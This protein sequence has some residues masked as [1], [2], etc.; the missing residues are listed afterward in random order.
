MPAVPPLKILKASAGSGK[1]FSLTAQYLTLLFADEHKYR[2]I[3]AITFTNKA[4]AEMKGRILGV[5]EALAMGDGNKGDAADG[6]REILLQAYPQWDAGA[7]Q[8]RAIAA[9]RKILHDYSR[10]AI[11]TIDGFTQKVIRGFTFELGIDAGYKLEMN[12]R[13]VKGD[14]VLRLN[15]TLDERPDL[16]QWIMDYAQAKIDRD[17]N[18][19]YRWAL[20]ELAAEIFKED[21][22]DFDKAVSAIPGQEL[23]VNL[24]RYCKE[25]IKQFEEA[26]EQLLKTA[27]GAFA[28]SGVDVTDLLGKSR[29]YLGKLDRFSAEDPA[30]AVKKLEKYIHNPA[31]W[32]KGGVNGNMAALYDVLNPLLEQIH[33]LYAEQSPDYYLAK[34]MDENLYYLRLLKEM[35]VL[36]AEWRHDNAAQLISDAQIL[37]SNIGTDQAGDP[38]FIWEKIGNRFRHFLFDEFQDTSKRQ[39]DNLRPLLINAMGNATGKRHEH[40]IVGDVKQSIYRWRNGDWRILLDRAEQ[41]IGKAF[42]TADTSPLIEHAALE[43]NYRSHEHIVAFNNLVF[44]HAPQ[45]LQQRLNDRVLRELGEAE[46]EHW[47]QPSGSHDM[48]IRAYADSRQQLPASARRGGTVHVEFIDVENNNHR[49]SAVKDEALAR[50]ADT[51]IGWLS[52]G[53][54]R[55]NQV[56]IL[57]RTNNE[58]REIIQYLLD[59]QRESGTAFDVV[60]GDALA[61]V[62]HPAIRLLVDTLRALA[63]KLPDTALYLANCIYLHNQLAG[64]A[65]AVAAHDWIQVGK[66]HP[67]QLGGM[68]PELLCNNWDMWAQLPLAELVE[69]LI[70][71]YGLQTNEES[72]PYLLAFRDLVAAFTANGERGIPAFLTYWEEEGIDRALPAAGETAAVEVL[73]IHKSKGLAF[74]V[75]MIPFCSWPIDGRINGNFWVNTEDTPYALLSK[76]PVKYKGDLGKSRLYQAYFEEMLLNYMDALNTL[77][78]A[79]TRT[80]KHLYIT[81]PGKKGDGEISALL[82]SDLLLEV[83]PGIAGELDV[84]FSDGIRLGTATE[85][86]TPRGQEPPQT[87]WSFSHY[88]ASTRMKEELARPEIQTELDVARLDVAKRQGQLLHKLMAETAA[89]AELEAYAD[90]L[91]A[92]GWLRSEE[93]SEVLALAQATWNHPQLAQWFSGEYEHWNERDVILPDGRTLRPDKILV[94]PDETIVLDFKFTQHENKAHLKQVAD[95][96]R[97]LHEMGMPHVKG[98]VYYGMLEKLVEV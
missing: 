90:V 30:D 14:L 7:L 76:T 57:V 97:V 1:T 12:I 52:S 81:A 18:W 42:N 8:Q 35:S 6:Y 13:K 28:A 58:A 40:L 95:Y 23:F 29:N 5:L 60:S 19:N 44:A 85:T 21:F 62:N 93:R 91:Q 86:D 84:E 26:F 67:V 50:L 53:T 39:W 51:L 16:L 96:Q 22:Q 2:E 75:V 68:L 88:P 87:G 34:A 20:N 48:L 43:I 24:D 71:A 41:Q 74:D 59:K 54:Y 70:V 78:V 11:S 25:V 15:R 66:C 36:L 64:R 45:W 61:L 32:Q 9:Y 79:T 65:A 38:T 69:S 92:E 31:E 89:T 47:W 63:G 27:A 56:G 83:L 94:R 3:L 33:V 80:R 46:Y 10:F 72:L 37:L 98:Y 73:T 49:A 55:P 77:Y 17:E 4:T 82:A